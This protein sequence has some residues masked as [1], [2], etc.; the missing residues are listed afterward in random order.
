MADV[1]RGDADGA[2]IYYRRL[3][4]AIGFSTPDAIFDTTLDDVTS[5]LGY[6]G[7][8]GADLQNLSPEILMTPAKLLAPCAVGE[9]DCV[10]TLRNRDAV[11][12][13]LDVIPIRPDDILVSRFFAPK[14]VNIK[15]PEAT[16]KLG[17]RKLVRLRARPGSVAAANHIGSGII[18]FNIFTNPEASPFSSGDESIN[19]QVML[20]TDP[21]QVPK[22]NT[23]ERHTLY[24]LDYGPLSQGGLLSLALE[25]SFDANELQGS[26]GGVQPYFVPDG[27]VACHGGNERR[28]MVNYLDTDHWFDR[29]E[30]DFASLKERGLALLVDAQTNDTEALS[31]IMA[32]DV[33]RRFNAEADAQVRAAQPKHDEA[34]A[35]Q[36]WLELHASSNEHIAPIGRAIGNEPRWSGDSPGDGKVLDAMNQFCFRCHGTVKFSVFDKQE[37]RKRRAVVK[38]RIKSDAP[39]GMKMPPD[40]ELPD[41]VRTFL[42]NA[43]P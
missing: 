15:E 21:S 42:Q 6:G 25:A 43:L 17:W 31:Y 11:L 27:C 9:S 7:I 40:R 2:K 34:L 4:T 19:T 37:V 28:S 39:V 26:D 10:N 38:Q 32:F 16:R 18:L 23:S 41:D 20:V 3:A 1:A 33:I 5:Y 13:S 14:I 24:W 12:A 36:K 30:N 29:L 22:P 35:S 8:T